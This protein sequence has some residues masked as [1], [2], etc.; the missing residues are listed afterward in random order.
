[1][2]SAAECRGATRVIKRG[3]GLPRTGAMA[4]VL[5]I[6]PTSLWIEPMK[7][8]F[9]VIS[10]LALF[11]AAIFFLCS[12]IYWNSQVRQR[13]GSTYFNSADAEE[14]ATRFQ[15]IEVLF[16]AMGTAALGSVVG[17]GLGIAGHLRGEAVPAIRCVAV[18]GNVLFLAY[19]L[20]LSPAIY[21]SFEA[22]SP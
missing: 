15:S 7:A 12:A 11:S 18:I 4:F 22:G 6:V 13:I 3:Q 2:T 8:R 17:V 21:A 20:L 9:P 10:I 14:D 1:M 5:D 19:G 16:R